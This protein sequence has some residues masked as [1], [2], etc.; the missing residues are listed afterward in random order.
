[1][2]YER[3]SDD[4]LLQLI[5]GRDPN[6]LSAL[7]DRYAPQT[8]AVALLITHEPAT[9]AV[10]IEEL[11]WQVWRCGATPQPGATVRNGLMLSA[12]RLAEHARLP[13]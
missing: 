5:A 9:A 4:T 11:F 10:V 13:A 2:L 12:R 3:L 7:Y 8:H 6:A 1:M